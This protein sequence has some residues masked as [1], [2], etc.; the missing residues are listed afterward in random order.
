M[1]F[2]FS[3]I[4]R[5]KYF[6]TLSV[7]V[8]SVF[9][10]L[11]SI[12]NITLYRTE[13]GPLYISLPWLY[14]FFFCPFFLSFFRSFF[15]LLVNWLVHP[16]VHS[17]DNGMFV[18]FHLLF[19]L[20]ISLSLNNLFIQWIISFVLLCVQVHRLYESGYYEDV[21]QLLMPTLH[22]PQPKT[23]V[24]SLTVYVVFSRALSS[25]LGFTL[26]SYWLLVMD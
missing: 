13:A 24:W 15:H 26:R 17:L 23:K 6:K 16:L 12:V 4:L 1:Y 14:L 25:L 5:N 3:F 22:Q 19:N 18:L 11:L 9:F 20:L 8:Q 2:F 21:V 10:V 7:L